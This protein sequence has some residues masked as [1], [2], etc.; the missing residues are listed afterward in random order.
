MVGVRIKLARDRL[1][2][3]QSELA[4]RLGVSQ[5]YISDVERGRVK[6][7]LEW[8]IRVAEALG[9][10]ASELDSRL[11]GKS[12]ASQVDTAITRKP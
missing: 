6:P 3:F 12:D 2:I 1:G 4:K 11:K 8:I 9:I 10:D 7:S 5:P